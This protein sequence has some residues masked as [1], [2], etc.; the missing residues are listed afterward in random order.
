[1]PS[2]PTRPRWRVCGAQRLYDGLGVP[3]KDKRYYRLD[4][5]DLRKF[6]GR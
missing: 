3:R 4:G 5:E 2:L 6:A 1:V